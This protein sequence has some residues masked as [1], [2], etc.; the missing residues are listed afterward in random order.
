[1]LLSTQRWHPEAEGVRHR[2]ISTLGLVL[3]VAAVSTIAQQAPLTIHGRVFA[4][5]NREALRHARVVIVVDREAGPPTYTDDRGEFSL[6][7]P[8]AAN[9]TLS[10]V[11]ATFAM[12]EMPL[13]RAALSATTQR[14]VSIALNR[15]AGINGRVVDPSDEAVVGLS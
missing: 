10:V 9:F 15:A 2:L 14:D 4:A 7:V 6:E 1:M 11:K 5:D 13:E 12:M 3:A 8:S